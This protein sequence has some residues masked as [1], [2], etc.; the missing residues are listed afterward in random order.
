MVTKNDPRHQLRQKIVSDLFAWNFHPQP[1]SSEA[2]EVVDALP[3]IDKIIESCAPEF[4]KD[5][6][7]HLDLAI[8]RLAV[9]ELTIKKTEPLKVIIDEAV[10]LAK[11]FGG[12]SSPAFVNGVLGAVVKNYVEP[13]RA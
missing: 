4:P 10:E 8:L 9:Y 13:E 1:V 6:I 11:E 12:E 3:N 5:K 2:Q 7:N